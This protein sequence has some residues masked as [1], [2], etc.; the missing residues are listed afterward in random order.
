MI[1]RG[2]IEMYLNAHK[3]IA[4]I[5]V[6][7]FATE[8]EGFAEK[9]VVA[10]EPVASTADKSAPVVV[11]NVVDMVM[12]S[13]DGE[14]YTVSDFKRYLERKG[15][16]VPEDVFAPPFDVH[17]YLKE[18]VLEQ[19][20]AKE[21]DQRGLTVG[22]KE[23][24]A[25]VN[26]I[27]KQ[28][29][30]EDEVELASLLKTQGMTM[31]RYMEA[32]KSDI[33][34]T[35]ILTT[36]VRS[37]VSVVDEDIRRYLAEH[38]ERI[39]GEGTVHIQQILIPVASDA[40]EEDRTLVKGT[41]SDLREKLVSGGNWEAVGKQHYVDLGYVALGDLKSELQQALEKVSPGE[42]SEVVELDS[43]YG[44]V[45]IAGKKDKGEDLDESFK[46]EIRQEL[47]QVRLAEK[48]EEF[49]TKD[50]PKKYHVEIKI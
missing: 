13:I 1:T 14:P 35:R 3:A 47:F 48:L 10:P 32:V 21:A 43:G 41:V 7:L 28:N 2:G 6:V 34:R 49:L 25:Y 31:E 42:V 17:T 18:M 22:E 9:L 19:I 38:P 37:K 26:E 27:K 50:L 33:I 45:Q 15:K 16:A 5:I 39:P 24:T 8:Q 20:L 11:D 4:L 30:V 29:G 44:V 23:I 46:E 12:V 36:A 40:T